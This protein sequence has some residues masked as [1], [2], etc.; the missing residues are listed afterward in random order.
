[1][2]IKIK[3]SELNEQTILSLNKLIDSDINASCAFR[4][5]RII[6]EIS[7][8]IEDKVKMEQKILDKWVKRDES[9]NPVHAKNEKGEVLKDSVVLTDTNEFNKDMKMLM[10]T[11]NNLPFD[12][13]K[14]DDLGLKT[15]KVSDIFK[16]EF[17]FE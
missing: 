14:F 7:S 1:M 4:L 2:S 8:I 10:E 12:K 3:N 11:E 15:A 9:G 17:L 5:T 6:K 16:L 13:I